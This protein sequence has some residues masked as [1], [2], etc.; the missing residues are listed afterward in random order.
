MRLQ[1]RAASTRTMRSPSRTIVSS[2]P[3]TRKA[4]GRVAVS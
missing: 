4:A 2:T 1:L 3:P